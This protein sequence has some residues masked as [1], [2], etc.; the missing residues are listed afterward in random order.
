M[1][2][3]AADAGG[4][5]IA[6]ADPSTSFSAAITATVLGRPYRLV[7]RSHGGYGDVGQYTVGATIV[8]P[9]SPV[10][11]PT[12][13][14]ASASPTGQVQLAWTDNA[15][16]ET[17]YGVERSTDGINWFQVASL[18]ADSHGYSDAATAA[19]MTYYSN[20]FRAWN[21]SPP[22][23]TRTRRRPRSPRQPRMGLTAT[24]ASSAPGRPGLV[25]TCPARRDTASSG[26]PTAASP[27]P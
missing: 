14:T 13:L 15:T 5:L 22:P 16:D 18:P 9:T 10:T 20:R 19:G 6:S 24:A 25:R 2:P 7:A 21:T 1:P 3:G 12:N 27:G 11:A 8:A 17:A 26:R 4:V 23:P